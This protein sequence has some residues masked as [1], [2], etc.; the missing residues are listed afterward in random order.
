MP[1]IRSAW[2]PRVRLS[3]TRMPASTPRLSSGRM[4]MAASLVLIGVGAVADDRQLEWEGAAAPPLPADQRGLGDVGQG[5]LG[6][7][8]AADDRVQLGGGDRP[9]DRLAV[10]GGASPAE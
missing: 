8:D 9:H 1:C 7:G 4:R 10:V 5:P 6:P 2:R 3:P